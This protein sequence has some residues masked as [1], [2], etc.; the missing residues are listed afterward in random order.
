MIEPQNLLIV[1]TDRIGDVVLSLPLAGIIRKHYPDCRI[2]FLLRKYSKPIAANHPHIDEVITLNE[3][4]NKI[5]L[6]ENVRRLRACKFD[7]AIIVYPTLIAAMI[8][9][10]AGIK[11]RIGTGYRWYSFLF[12]KRV[13]EHR[14]YAEKHELEYNVNLLEQIGIY[15]SISKGNVKFSLKEDDNAL[16]RVRNKVVKL[17]VDPGKP[18]IILHPGSGGSSVDLPLNKFKELAKYISDSNLC[19]L[20][21]TGLPS[22]KQLAS[23]VAENTNAINAA[24]EFDLNELIAFISLSKLFI[25][26][27]TGP[28]HIAAALGKYTIGFYPKLRA[29]SA[30]RWGPYSNKSFVYKP[31]T[32]CDDCNREQCNKIDCMN[33]IDMSAVFSKVDQIIRNTDF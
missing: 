10:F 9:F 2:T 30:E 7:T 19:N 3:E 11:I 17:G 26:N 15:E 6:I 25:A 1:R 5:T 22:E 20:V 21:I 29:C 16:R 33:S 23:A 32:D 28:L 31:E 8:V 13:F 24:G 18:L 12:N 4:N 14:K 27:S